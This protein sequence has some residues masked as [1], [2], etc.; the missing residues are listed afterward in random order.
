MN[1]RLYFINELSKNTN[2][3]KDK[4]IFLYLKLSTL[5]KEY[6]ENNNPLAF[7]KLYKSIEENN[8]QEI[9]QLFK[10]NRIIEANDEEFMQFLGKENFIKILNYIKAEDSYPS[11]Y[12]LIDA[13]DKNFNK[14]LPQEL[15]DL[16]IRIFLNFK[17]EI[18][19]IYNPYPMSYDLAYNLNKKLSIPVYTEDGNSTPLPYLMNLLD[20]TNIHPK[21]SDPIKSPSFLETNY[22]L[23]LFDYSVAFLP[24]IKKIEIQNDIYNRF[25]FSTQSKLRDSVILYIEHILAQT[26]LKAFI[27]T[28]LS[29]LNRGVKA[30][31][32]FREWLV[33]NNYID[34]IILFPENI[35]PNPLASVALIILNKKK[36]DKEVLFVDAS[37]KFKKAPIGRKNILTDIDLIA[38]IYLSKESKENCSVLISS[39][40]IYENN[41]SLNPKKYIKSDEEKHF[42]NLLNDLKTIKLKEIAEIIQSPLIKRKTENLDKNIFEVQASDISENN[43]I[44]KVANQ[45]KVSLTNEEINNHALKPNDLVIVTRSGNNIGNVG[46]V[47]E[48][49]QKEIWIPGQTLT[50]IRTKEKEI[51]FY[52]YFLFK[53]TIGKY[54]INTSVQDSSIKILPVKKLQNIDIPEMDNNKDI[55]KYFQQEQE[56]YKKIK[57]LKK[58]SLMIPNQAISD[59]LNMSIE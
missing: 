12:N 49:P 46:L 26:K 29:F 37:N 9:I 41:F 38:H 24:N 34:A 44:Q 11:V 43:I 36:K 4:L 27:F 45:K 10:K 56:I 25:N 14:R 33:K 59:V 32:N 17:D 1:Y 42:E 7:I 39:E 50:I 3:S 53:T 15:L 28:N 16:L 57:K 23:T 58:E 51:T 8:Y 18:T 19:S 22:S 47:L 48:I 5:K 13:L 6:Y 54:L 40:K 21:F 31:I 55:L 30:E 35:L 2:I 52:L 20:N